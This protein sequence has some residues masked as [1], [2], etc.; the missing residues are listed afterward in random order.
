MPRDFTDNSWQRTE[1]KN[2]GLGLWDESVVSRAHIED[3][4]CISAQDVEW[5]PKGGMT[6]RSGIQRLNST[7]VT[8]TPS[9]LQIYQWQTNAG[10]DVILAFM[11][12]SA[13]WSSS[14][15]YVFNIASEAGSSS[16]SPVSGDSALCVGWQPTGLQQ[17][18]CASFLGSAVFTYGDSLGSI[19]VYAGGTLGTDGMTGMKASPSGCYCVETWGNFLLAANTSNGTSRVEWCYPGNP[20]ANPL[21]SGAGDATQWPSSYYLDLD[22][23]DG[24]AIVAMKAFQDSIV[25]FKRYKMYQVNWVGGV[26]LFDYRRISTEIGCNGADAL[27]EHEGKLWWLGPRGFYVWDGSQ[28]PEDLSM[29]INPQIV[30][31]DSSYAHNCFVRPYKKNNQIF[32]AIPTTSSTKFD[33]IYVYDYTLNSWTTFNISARCLALV[34]ESTTKT[35]ASFPTSYADWDETISSTSK[36]GADLIAIGYDAGLIKS[37]GVGTSDDGADIDAY[38]KSGWLDWDMPER[39]K[40]VTRITYLVSVQG[41]VDYSLDVQMYKDWAWEADTYSK[42]STISLYEATTVSDRIVERRWDQSLYLRSLQLKLG[43]NL[44]S[45]PFTVHKIVIDWV[46]K[47]R[48]Q[49]S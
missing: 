17:I 24:D 48:T 19:Q 14:G 44:A 16:F 35:F 22:P 12:Q 31:I 21:S 4:A 37:Y 32:V 1:L 8:G 11:D 6:K 42:Q 10:S 25:V 13:C 34:R 45:E 23:D 26:N 5:L 39:N 2:F 20:W 30:N 43:T 15:V 3:G 33:V 40:R 27:C 18:S 46:A 49:G 28:A 41:S 29:A 47:G 7:S 9:V 38:W 36:R